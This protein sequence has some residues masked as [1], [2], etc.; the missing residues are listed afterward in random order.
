ML[1][2]CEHS[3]VKLE[4]RT[5]FY[6]E[7]PNRHVRLSVC[8]VRASCISVKCFKRN[9]LLPV[10]I[11]A[12]LMATIVDRSDPLSSAEFVTVDPAMAA[13]VDRRHRKI[14]DWLKSH[15][16]DAALL[17]DPANQSWLSA[18]ADFS[19]AEMSGP[20]T[21][22]FVTPES[23][24]I[25]CHNVASSRVFETCIGGMGFQ[26]K[27]RPW[28]EPLEVL[29]ADLC[30]SRKVVL[31]RFG[32]L[33]EARTEAFRNFR[34]PLDD[35]DVEQLKMGSKIITHAVEATCRG[36]YPG[37]RECELAG[38]VSHRLLKHEVTPVRVQILADGR[39]RRFRDWAWSED[40]TTSTV[41]IVAIGR[42]KGMHCGVSRT[43]LDGPLEGSFAEAWEKLALVLGTAMFFSLGSTPLSQIWG[44][45]ARIYEKFGCADEWEM[46]PQG[47][48]LDYGR[49]SAL[50]TPQSKVA[51]PARGAIFWRPSIAMAMA[52]E[53][54][55][56]TEEGARVLTHSGDWPT[57]DV[58]I[59][60]SHVPVTA[61]LSRSE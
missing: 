16:F 39:A 11:E 50:I 59:K 13:L 45:V 61:I 26:I 58:E 3:I 7:I 14:A 60:G 25:V 15:Q 48:L 29:L 8:F 49:I 24:V 32:P 27:E 54:V 34:W 52:G 36:W 9:P 43:V 40:E 57:W 46:A 22:M 2:S 51:V 31:D 37:K 47:E 35:H 10:L 18:G 19:G 1:P 44:K 53:T 4:S 20:S 56:A 33:G 21:A 6:G 55:L 42:Y 38:E 23:R 17:T 30:R 28:Y 5:N 12:P 41:T